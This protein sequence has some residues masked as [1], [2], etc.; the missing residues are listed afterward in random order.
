LF[1]VGF[2]SSTPE[3]LRIEHPERHPRCLS[4]LITSTYEFPDGN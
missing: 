3:K 4:H 2:R 1:G